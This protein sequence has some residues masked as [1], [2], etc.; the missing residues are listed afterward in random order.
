MF[1]YCTEIRTSEQEA[2]LRITPRGRRASTDAPGHVGRRAAPPQRHRQLAP[3]LTP[4]NRE[5]LLQ[6]PLTGPSGSRGSR[7]GPGGRGP[8][9][10]RRPEL[11][12]RSVMCRRVAVTAPTLTVNSVRTEFRRRRRHRRRG[13]GNSAVADDS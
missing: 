9:C 10:P 8:M 4:A 3:H 12:D 6:T 11:P 2:Y 5:V 1:V 7:G 13:T